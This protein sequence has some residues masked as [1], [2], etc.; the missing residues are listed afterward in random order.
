V[1]NLNE[2]QFQSSKQGEQIEGQLPMFRTTKAG[3]ANVYERLGPEETI[4]DEPAAAPESTYV[5]L[6]L[7]TGLFDGKH[8][9]R[10]VFGDFETSPGSSEMEYLENRDPHQRAIMQSRS[11]G[12]LLGYEAYPD[13]VNPDLYFQDLERSDPEPVGFHGT[14]SRVDF[15]TPEG[16]T[17][18]RV[19]YSEN[20]WGPSI[21]TAEVNPLYKG[22]GFSKDAMIDFVSEADGV[23]HADDFTAEGSKAFRARGI[24]TGLDLENMAVERGGGYYDEGVR[25]EAEHFQKAGARHLQDR[26]R[27]SLDILPP[28]KPV[29]QRKLF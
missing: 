20:E 4:P 2:K 15:R 23:V 13:R 5:P 18:G 17:V 28:Q 16:T 21:D 24:P 26:R 12:T 27:R 9:I 11:E 25:L 14:G 29:E 19:D 7:S 3:P 8:A 22:R 6:E 10:G 1:P